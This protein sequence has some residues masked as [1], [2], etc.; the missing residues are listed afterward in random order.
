MAG[1]TPRL[2]VGLYFPF[3]QSSLLTLDTVEVERTGAGDFWGH[4]SYLLTPLEWPLA[5]AARAEIKAP[6]SKADF[7][8]L[9]L[10][11]SEGQFDATPGMVA[12][13]MPLQNL[14]LS[15]GLR[16]RYRFPVSTTVGAVN[17]DFKPGNEWE[18]HAEIGGSFWRPLWLSGG[19]R[20]TWS[21]V[22]QRRTL[23]LEWEDTEER[24]FHAL[25]ASVYFEFLRPFSIDSPLALS[26]YSQVPM[27]GADML[28]GPQVMV[29]LAWQ[30]QI[31]E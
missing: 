25:E 29:G 12:S 5:L 30:A 9:S 1:L 26:F 27:A 15:S 22:A 19:W 11:L 18:Y 13:W 7:Q 28:S 17:V 21:G 20:S 2:S 16:W 24:R 14:M 23:N 31:W 8:V 4:A 10:P 6:L 3:W